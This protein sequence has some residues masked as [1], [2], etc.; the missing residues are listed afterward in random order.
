[1]PDSWPAK[2][3]E[4]YASLF[5]RKQG[6]VSGDVSP[7]Y[8]SIP[9]GKVNAISKLF[10]QTR[11]LYVLR[12]PMERIISDFSMLSNNRGLDVATMSDDDVLKTIWD[13]YAET[14]DYAG[15][16]AR[17]RADFPVTV[18]FYDELRADP[19]AFAHRVCESLGIRPLADLAANTENPNPSKSYGPKPKLSPGVMRE[20]ATR[21]VPHAE[22]INTLF[23]NAYTRAWLADL[24]QRSTGPVA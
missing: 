9:A 11:I 22:A 13:H 14:A 20:L 3:T 15:I 4:W 12:H 17:W 21:L 23:D 2:T 18:L 10:P 16:Y 8:Q 19:A 1:M 7:L 6:Q 5:R 24:Q